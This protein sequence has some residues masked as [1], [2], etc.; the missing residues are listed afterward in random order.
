M[1][2]QAHGC[3]KILRIAK[4]PMPMKLIQHINN[5]KMW[6]LTNNSHNSLFGAPK[7]TAFLKLQFFFET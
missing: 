5:R 3:S 7:T 4:Q 1:E 6:H 2:F